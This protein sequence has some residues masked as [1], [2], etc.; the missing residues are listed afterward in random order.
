MPRP[1]TAWRGIGV[2]IRPRR[3]AGL[4]HALPPHVAMPDSRL[5]WADIV[6]GA[7]A[8]LVIALLVI[9]VMK[10]ARVGGVRG[11][12]VRLF[13]TTAE[14]RGIIAGTTEVWLLGQ[15]VGVVRDVDFQSVGVDTTHRLLLELELKESALQ[16]LRR[17]SD[18]QIRTGGSL[19][20]A[21]VVYLTSG[22]PAAGAVEKRDTIGLRPQVDTENISSQIALASRELPAIIANVKTIAAQVEGARGTAGAILGDGP[23]SR[24]MGRFSSNASSLVSRA[25]RGNGTIALAMRGDLPG[26]ARGAMARA[27]SIR[28]LLSSGSGTFGRFTR[29][30]TLLREVAA[31][32]AE[33]SIVSALMAQPAGTA[34]RITRDSAL[35][36]MVGR[37]QREMGELFEDIKQR[38]MRYLAF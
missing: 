34:G 38:P 14:A 1:A 32:R 18:A 27:D 5:R 17:D 11:D 15:K 23:G 3:T 7:L 24:E 6:P 9:G 10:Y 12:T 28:T 26:R 16:Y 30:S 19:I 37:A 21:P 36:V 8:L 25:T 2:F 22:T 20:G 4:V 13:A 33:L 31:V 29:D 35:F